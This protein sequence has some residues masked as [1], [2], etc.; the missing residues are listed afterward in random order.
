MSPRN[1]LVHE[2]RPH[3]SSQV[4]RPSLLPS[5]LPS[6]LFSLLSSL[7]PPTRSR[8]GIS[9]P[10]LPPFFVPRS[11][12][13]PPSQVPMS[14]LG[15]ARPPRP[16]LQGPARQ[17]S[18]APLACTTCRTRKVRDVCPCCREVWENVVGGNSMSR[19]SV[20]GSYHI[21]PP[22]Q[23]I[24]RSANMKRKGR[25]IPAARKALTGLPLS[26]WLR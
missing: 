3:S 18:S 21:V 23:I 12:L 7:L 24:P 14:E 4:S 11:E 20:T 26:F 6:P 5:L 13:F 16:A 17:R 1:L 9:L 2:S 15:A 19:S 25:G 10:A 22:V 8:V